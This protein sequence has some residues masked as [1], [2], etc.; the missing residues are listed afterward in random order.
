M[1]VDGDVPM[2]ALAQEGA[3]QALMR[4]GMPWHD[5]LMLCACLDSSHRA[6]LSKLGNEILNNT[7]DEEKEKVFLE[8]CKTKHLEKLLVL[9]NHVVF[10]RVKNG[11]MEASANALSQARPGEIDLVFGRITM[12]LSGHLNLAAPP[13]YQE[14]ARIYLKEG[15]PFLFDRNG[16]SI[17]PAERIA[18]I[19]AASPSDQNIKAIEAAIDHAKELDVGE[20]EWKLRRVLHFLRTGS[21][22]IDLLPIKAER[23]ITKLISELKQKQWEPR[24]FARREIAYPVQV[25]FSLM[26]ASNRR[27]LLLNELA[28][29][30]NSHPNE[31]VRKWGQSIVQ[32]IF[33]KDLSGMRSE[34][35]RSDECRH[36]LGKLR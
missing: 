17:S 31:E 15:A 19:L 2:S 3:V 30:F 5:A 22:D 34:I 6:K 24:L 13:K 8:A 35:M 1:P 14:L 33:S 4:H 29:A 12:L 16:Y 36:L 28:A 23:V 27:E 7:S 11:L 25:E 10:N 32:D 26:G 21:E 20:P 9:H 18:E